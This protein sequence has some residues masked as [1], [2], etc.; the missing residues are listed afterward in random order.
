[1]QSEEWENPEEE[2]PGTTRGWGKRWTLVGM[3]VFGSN[4]N[5]LE[6]VTM[7][8]KPRDRTKGQ[9]QTQDELCGIWTSLSETVS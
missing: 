3:G 5:V 6:S 7:Q 2:Q 4:G 9:T 8:A 1:M